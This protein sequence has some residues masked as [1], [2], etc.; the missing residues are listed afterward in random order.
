MPSSAEFRGVPLDARTEDYLRGVFGETFVRA[1]RDG[2]LIL[3]ET[4][5]DGVFSVSFDRQAYLDFAAGLI[6][7]FGTPQPTNEANRGPR[8][9]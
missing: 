5:D 4:T 6:R 7:R 3:V 8:A 1:A 2:D 9:A